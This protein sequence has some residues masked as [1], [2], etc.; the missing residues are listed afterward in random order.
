MTTAPTSLPSGV[1]APIPRELLRLAVPVLLSQLLRVAYQWVDAF[2][3]RGLGVD[4]TAAV[5]TSMF[6]MWT[7][8]S[9]Y[10]V[11]GLGVSAYVSQLLGAGDRKRAGVAA[12]KGL[13]V[14]ALMGLAGTAVGLFGAREV[15]GL[16]HAAPAV[17]E[18]GGQ[19]LSVVLLGAPVFMMALSCESV[20]RAAGDTRTPLVADLC[21]VALN[22][23]LAPFLV[24]GVGPIP[25]LGVAGAA[26]ATVISQCVLVA[27]YFTL[28]AR[29][30]RALPLA[31]RA[32]GA[33]IRIAGMARVG[34]PA[35]IIGMMFS[36]VYIA[37]ARSAGRYGA[38]SLAIV[39]IVNRVEALQFVNAIALGIAGATLVG[40]NLGAGRPDRAAQVIRTGLKWSVWVSI[41]FALLFVFFPHFFLDLF[42][43]DPEVHRLGAPY[44]RILAICLPFVA[45]EVVTAEAI[46]GSGHTR[47]ISWIFTTF[48]LLRIPLAFLVPEWTGLG[49]LGIAWV[50]TITCIVRATLIALWAARGTWKTGLAGELRT[51]PP[52]SDPAAVAG[53]SSGGASVT[54]G[55]SVE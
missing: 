3:V 22:A 36:V 42:T 35:A 38:A 11:F 9:L 7:V 17:T 53:A 41:V 55:A 19:Y 8:Y 16:M 52:V 34:L 47:P 23:A 12:W 44:L 31:R 27:I 33:P 40:Q 1:T 54:P 26:W 39:G 5:T 15:Y 24:Y 49:V 4:A 51:T 28:A 25:A 18:L 37:F 21:A 10:D 50:I 20:M 48:S 13:R 6:V 46:I 2:W 29:G 30:H 14:S 43:R 45:V 32:P